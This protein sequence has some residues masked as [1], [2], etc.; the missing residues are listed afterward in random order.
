MT[1]ACSLL[2]GTHWVYQDTSL[3][4]YLLQVNHHQQ[5]LEIQEFGIGFLPVEANGYRQNCGSE[6]KEPQNHTLPTPRFD[7]KFSTWNLPSHVGGTYPQNCMVENPRNQISD[8]HFDKS[9]GTSDFQC[10]KTNFKTE[11]CSC[12]GCPAI[13]MLWI[14]EVE[15]VK[16]VDDLVASQS[17]GVYVFPNF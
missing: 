17:I 14:K 11:A 7:R 12:S 16:S 3:K 5:S 13:A 9:P 4:T 10:W 1:L 15:V 2:H 8:L 6:R